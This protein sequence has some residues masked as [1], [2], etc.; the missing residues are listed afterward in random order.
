M[1]P[2]PIYVP[3]SVWSQSI[4]KALKASGIAQVAYVPDAGHKFLIES[5]HADPAIKMIPLTTEEEGVALAAGAWLGGERAAL[6]MQSSGAGNCINMLSIADEC[7]FPLLM[8]ITMRGAWGETNPWQVPMGSR[9]ARVLEAAGVIVQQV[10]AADS[11]GQEVEMAAQM[12]FVSNRAVAVL[13]GQRLIGAKKF[14]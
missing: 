11:L 8:L 2:D 14:D 10:D 4:F 6:L 12:A 7:R 5:C 3:Q 9:T 1:T 13:L